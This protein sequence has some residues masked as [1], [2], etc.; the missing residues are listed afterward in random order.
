MLGLLNNISKYYID[1][2]I[3]FKLCAYYYFI[4]Y[5]KGWQRLIYAQSL[6]AYY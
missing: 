6:I 4:I 1:I 2:I 3:I 5:K